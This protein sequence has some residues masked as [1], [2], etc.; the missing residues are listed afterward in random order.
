MVFARPL[1]M[2]EVAHAIDQRIQQTKKRL[3]C[4]F[5]LGEEQ[6]VGGQLTLTDGH[7]ILA[8]GP[9]KA[10]P[11][12]TRLQPTQVTQHTLVVPSLQ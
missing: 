10:Q 5:P 6:K 4:T 2:H 8:Q 12:R 3:R 9:W 11:N 1:S 7:E